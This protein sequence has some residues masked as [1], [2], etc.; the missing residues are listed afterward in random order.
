MLKMDVESPVR[1]H[2]A[3]QNDKPQHDP[4]VHI[5]DSKLGI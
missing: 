2:Q 3:A 4:G 5:N 1:K